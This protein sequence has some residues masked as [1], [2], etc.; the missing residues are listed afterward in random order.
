[1]IIHTPTLEDYIEVI[2][3][4]LDKNFEW[5][6]GSRSINESQWE[7]YRSKTCVVID[8]D[9]LISYNNVV[10]IDDTYRIKYMLDMYK[11]HR[12]N[13]EYFVTKFAKKFD[14]R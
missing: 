5:I 10:Y 1:M 4:S 3:W 2:E 9:G 14:L 7:T 8:E 6:N 12:L 13:K 11:F